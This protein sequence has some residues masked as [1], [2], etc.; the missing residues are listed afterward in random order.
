M[1]RTSKHHKKKKKTYPVLSVPVLVFFLPTRLRVWEEKNKDN[2]LKVSQK[3]TLCSPFQHPS[4]PV[5][6]SLRHREGDS[7]KLFRHNHTVPA[8]PPPSRRLLAAPGPM[9]TLREPPRRPLREK[10]PPGAPLSSPPSLNNPM[11]RAGGEY[12]QGLSK[13]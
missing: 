2:N 3:H 5:F 9:V 12:C 11:G 8:A 4:V 13:V 10:E 7:K 1:T 6:Q